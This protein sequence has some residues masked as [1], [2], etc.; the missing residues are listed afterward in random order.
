MVGATG[1]LKRKQEFP[2]TKN[3]SL[4]A[5]AAV[6]LVAF[7]ATSAFAQAP[8]K[9]ATVAIGDD[10]SSECITAIAAA[11]KGD[12]KTV[13]DFL[14]AKAPVTDA[15]AYDKAVALMKQATGSRQAGWTPYPPAKLQ[16]VMELL[17]AAGCK[18]AVK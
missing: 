11:K 1:T 8:A 3:I 14:G 7:G 12:Q 18:S 10:N 9:G 2:M 6:A 16:E 13:N 5:L 17:A 4:R 15:K